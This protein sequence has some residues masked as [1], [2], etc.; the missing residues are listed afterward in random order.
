MA[1]GDAVILKRLPSSVRADDQE[2]DVFR[3]CVGRELVVLSIEENGDLELD[4]SG[5]GPWFR[6]IYVPPDCIELKT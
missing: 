2:D 1:I 3:D 5:H 6:S 4:V